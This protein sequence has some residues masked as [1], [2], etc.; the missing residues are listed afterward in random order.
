MDKLSQNTNDNIYVD[1][2]FI[3]QDNEHNHISF[4][5]VKLKE[6][7]KRIHLLSFYLCYGTSIINIEFLYTFVPLILSDPKY[8][9]IP[10]HKVPQLVGLSAMAAQMCDFSGCLILGYVFDN[11][12]RKMPLI[13]SQFIAGSAILVMALVPNVPLY[14]IMRCITTAG[15]AVTF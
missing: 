1:D 12:G 8:Y 14:Y 6:G 4:L 13:I 15:R 2:N 9:N 3:E 11:Y 7:I 10:L 5:G